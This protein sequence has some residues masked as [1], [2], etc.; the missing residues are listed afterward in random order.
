MRWCLHACGRSPRTR[1]RRRR[2]SSSGWRISSPD[3]TTSST[4]TS[5]ASIPC[6]A[7]RSPRPMP[8]SGRS[9]RPPRRG[10]CTRTSSFTG[11]LAGARA[12]RGRQRQPVDLRAVEPRARPLGQ[13]EPARHRLDPALLLPRPGGLRRRPLRL[14]HRR[15]AHAPG[16]GVCRRL[17]A[18]A[19]VRAPRA[20]RPGDGRRVPSRAEPSGRVAA[21]PRTAARVLRPAAADRL[22]GVPE[23]GREGARPGQ[24]HHRGDGRRVRRRGSGARRWAHSR[25]PATPTPTPR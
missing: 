12:A 3:A 13:H 11:R 17:L 21:R 19:H 7:G 4:R 5:R 9:R 14:P 1:S 24:G 16:D 10:C 18:L 15:D 20:P 8:V 25:S 2:S 23:R 6:S 22:R